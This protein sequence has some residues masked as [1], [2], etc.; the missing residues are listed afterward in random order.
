ML[1]T[2]VRFKTLKQRGIADNWVRVKDL[3]ANHGF[4]PGRLLSP[5]VR[6]WTE[7]ELAEWLETRPV[8]PAA[9]R[10]IAARLEAKKAARL[11]QEP[12]ELL[13]AEES[14]GTADSTRCP[15]A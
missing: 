3:I 15:P 2:F 1:P 13:K 10:G 9:P 11:Q 8:E 5:Q 4:P 14:D 7:D 12:P 6:V